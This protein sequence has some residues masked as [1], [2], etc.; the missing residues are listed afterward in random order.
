MKSHKRFAIF[1]LI[2]ILSLISSI[3]TPPAS[4]AQIKRVQ[5]GDVYFD[6]DD[7]S[8]IVSFDA[9][10]QTKTLVF[11]YPDADYTTVHL[12][13]NTLFT[14]QFESDSSLV[15][16]RAAGS[17]GATVRYYLIEFSEG[18]TVQRG[19]SSFL[20]GVITN[21]KYRIK[22]IAL[23]ES[24][25]LDKSISF[26][27]ASMTQSYAYTDELALI[28]S[29]IIN[30]G[31]TLRLE[32]CATN[33]ETRVITMIWQVIEFDTDTLV[34]Q[35]ETFIG[36]S[37]TYNTSAISPVIPAGKLDKCALFYSYRAN[38]TVNGN[39]SL[40]RI[41]GSIQNA[42]L[43]N[44]TRGNQTGA[45][46]TSVWVDWYVAEFQDESTFVQ[47]NVTTLA[48]GET[49]GAV[50]LTN[51][52][53]PARTFVRV[54]VA[55]PNTQTNTY[56]DDTELCP[57]TEKLQ[58]LAF[59][60]STNSIWVT[61]YLTDS[62]YK[63]NA[64]TGNLTGTYPVGVN[65]IAVVY[66]PSNLAV[67]VANYGSNNVTKLYASNGTE[68]GNYS[69][70]T[71][72]MDI[73]YDYSNATTQYI[74]TANYGSQNVTKLYANNGTLRCT[75]AT[76]QVNPTSICYDP[77]G[78]QIY[79]TFW[80]GSTGEQASRAPCYN[81]NVT[82]AWNAIDTGTT[83]QGQIRV[84]W[85][86][87]KGYTGMN[88][89]SGSMWITQQRLHQC[90]RIYV[91][92]SGANYYPELSPIGVAWDNNTKT[93]WITNYASNTLSKMYPNNG[94]DTGPFTTI[95]N[96]YDVVYAPND[97]SMWVSC[98][99]PASLQ[100]FD[101][102]GTLLGTYRLV[103]ISDTIY[104]A[105]QNTGCNL[106][107]HWYVGEFSPVNIK[108]PNGV[109]EV[110]RV[111]QVK[112]IN[113]T[114]SSDVI[115]H[116]LAISA[117]LANS[118][119]ISNYTVINGSVP[120]SSNN[121]GTFNWNVTS[122]IGGANS[123][124]KLVRIGIKDTNLTA[125]NY[126][127]SNAPFEIK[128]DI[129]AVTAPVGGEDWRV[130]ESHDI[131]WTKAGDLSAN[132][133]SISLSSDGGG[134]WTVINNTTSGSATTYNWTIPD[135]AET[136]GSMRIN[137]SWEGDPLN[138]TAMSPAN[139]TVRAK[140]NVT[141]PTT[142]V[143]WLAQS[144]GT[145]T[146]TRNGSW[147]PNTVSIYY[148]NATGTNQLINGSVPANNSTGPNVGSYF[149][150]NITVNASSAA[151]RIYI[152]SNVDSA[153]NSTSEA[154][155]IFPYIEVTYPNTDDVVWNVTDSVP[156]NWTLYGSMDTVDIW[157]NNSSGWSKLGDSVNASG[158][159]WMWYN[160]PVSYASET[161]YIWVAK[162]T[163]AGAPVIP[164]DASNYPA[165]IRGKISVG[166]PALN[167]IYTIN[168]SQYINW[169][170]SGF[171]A[172]EKVRIKFSPS[173]AMDPG[174]LTNLTNATT[175]P[176]ANNQTWTW[177]AVP[178]NVTNVGKIR[179][180]WT[181]NNS[182][183]GDSANFSIK[184]SIDVNLPNTTTT[185]YIGSAMPINWSVPAASNGCIGAVELRYVLENG[186]G[187]S[188]NIS[189]GT[190]WWFDESGQYSWPIPESASISDAV[191]IKAVMANDSSNVSNLSS[192]PCRIMGV[193]NVTSPDNGTQAWKIGSTYPITWNRNGTNLGNINITFFNGSSNITI[194]S[195]YD[196]AVG[197][198]DWTVNNTT[199][200]SGQRMDNVTV[201][202]ASIT[203]PSYTY[204]ISSAPFSIV[205]NI[206][207]TWPDILN[208]TLYVDTNVTI[209][210]TVL[211]D[212]DK[213]NVYYSQDGGST[214]GSPI[215][216]GE[217]NDGNFTWQVPNQNIQEADSKLKICNYYYNLTPSA[218][219]GESRSFT[220]KQNIEILHPNATD[221]PQVGQAFAIQFMPHGTVG[222]VNISWY[223]GS[224]WTELVNNTS[225]TPGIVNT[226]NWPEVPDEMSTAVNRI[227]IESET[228]G[229]VNNTS[230]LFPIVGYINVTEPNASYYAKA[231]S[232]ASAPLRWSYS[233]TKVGDVY[234]KYSTNDGQNWTNISTVPATYGGNYTW[235]LVP[236]LKNNLTR[237]SVT[238]VND[239]NTT[240]MSER[241]EIIGAVTMGLPNGGETWKADSTRE[242]TW[243]AE[244]VSTVSLYYSVNNGTGWTP[245]PDAEGLNA[246]DE[247]FNW[248]ISN[249]M[250]ITAN[251][252]IRIDDSTNSTINDTSD[253]VFNIAPDIN[254]LHPETQADVLIAEESGNITWTW[255]GDFDNITLQYSTDN[256]GNWSYV[257]PATPQ[258]PNTGTYEWT[259][260]NGTVI[261]KNCLVRISHPDNVTYNSTS[262]ATFPIRGKITLDRP[263]DPNEAWRMGNTYP[264]NWTKQGNMSTVNI[265]YSTN[266]GASWARINPDAE[267]ASNGTY[268]WAI[269]ATTTPSSRARISVNYTADEANVSAMSAQYFRVTKLAVTAP[270]GGQ[271]WRSGSTYEITWQ[272]GNISKV[273]VT[274]SLTNG[275]SWFAV[276]NGTDINASDNSLNW[277]VGNTTNC[278]NIALIRVEDTSNATLN[279]TSDA[280]FAV[281]PNFTI[282]HPRNGDPVLAGDPYN[283]T[284][285][286]TGS[287]IGN[288][289]IEY[290]TGGNSSWISI[291][292]SASSTSPYYW[293]SVSGENLSNDCYVRLT[294][295]NNA[296]G[297]NENDLAF[298]IRGNITL[299]APIGG[300]DFQVGNPTNVTWTKSGNFSSVDIYYSP[301]N[302]SN[303]SNWT[304]I[305][306]SP[307]NAS[308][309]TYQ[310]N[311]TYSET[312]TTQGLIR[313]L[314]PDDGLNATYDT[315]SDT[316]NIIG[317]LVLNYPND[318][319]VVLTYDG[320]G[321][322][323]Q[324]NWTRYGGIATVNLTYK[325]YDT[326]NT[327]VI[328]SSVDASLQKYNWTIPDEVGTNMKVRIRDNDNDNVT[329]ESNYSFAIKGTIQLIQ[330]NGNENWTVNSVP[331]PQIQW[332][333]R[334]AYPGMILI[335]YATDN[336]TWK[337][338][339]TMAA[340]AD[341]ATVSYNW[342]VPDDIANTV[343]ARV[344]TQ[345]SD[346]KVDVNDTSDANFS[347]IGNI[348][349]N[350]PTGGQTFL[351]PDS[352]TIDINWTAKGT[353][354]P[355]RIEY[356]LDNGS[357]WD[358]ITNN[359]TG[360]EGYNN[361]SWPTPD[362][363]SARCLIKVSDN[364]TAF[365]DH[366]TN[367]SS[368]V[369][370]IW[371]KL[372]LTEPVSGQNVVAHS[373]DTPIRWTYTGTK[374][375]NVTI[376][377]STNGGTNYSAIETVAV[378]QNGTYVWPLVPTT[379]CDDNARVSITD[380]DDANIS[381]ATPLFNIVGS[382]LL[383][384]PNGGENWTAGSSRQI[385]W[386]RFAVSTLN[387]S[388]STNNGGIWNDINSSY[389]TTTNTSI[390]WDIP[391]D[392]AI[393][394]QA[395]IRIQDTANPDNVSDI[396]DNTFN[397]TASLNILHP[398]T[399]SDV[400][401][402]EDTH[403][404]TWSKT[405]TGLS[406]VKLEYSTD[407][408]GNWSNVNATANVDNNGNYTWVSVNG[409]ALSDNCLVRISDPD[410][411]EVN[412][413]SNATFAIKGKIT[414]TRPNDADENWRVGTAQNITWTKQGN[415]SSVNIYY[416]NNSG[417]SWTKVNAAPVDCAG[418]NYSWTI[419]ASTVPSTQAKISVN[420]TL[421]ESNVSDSSTNSFNV[422][423]L[424]VTSPNAGTENW[425]AGS[426]YE[427]TWSSLAISKVNIRYSTNG[428]SSYTLV[429]G[430]DNVTASDQSFNWTVNNTTA[431]S[432]QALIL[433]EDSSN[434]TVN[435]TSNSTFNFT[436]DL[437]I[438]HPETSGD[439][440]IA[441]DPYY[442]TWSKT[443][444]G[445]SEVKLEYSTDGGGNW[446]NV[447]GT[448]N[449]D[450]N[451]NYT[452]TSVN[453][454]KL[455]DNCLVRVSDP[456]KADSNS[457]SSSAFPI[458]GKITLT[459]PV[460]ADENWRIGTIHNIT[461]TKQ[462]NMSSVNIY[463]SN[464]SGTSWTKVN[465]APVDCAGGNYSWTINASTVPSTQAKI[466]VNYTGDEL[467]VSS[468]ST[469][470][471]NVTKLM[472]TSPN[473][474]TES[475]KSGA[476]YEITWSSLAISKVNLYYSLNN[477]SS[478]TAIPDA[479][480][481]TASNQS[482]NWTIN[483]SIQLSNQTLVLVGDSSNATV[484]DTSN[485][486]FSIIPDL[487]ILHPETQSDVFIAEDTHYITWSKTGTGLSEVKLE[488]S[489]DNGGNW[490]NVNATANVDNN[491]NYTWVSV[492][493]TALSDNC[494]VRVSDPSRA[495]VNSTSN[496][497]FAIKGKVTLTR[498]NDADENW[499][500]GTT[501]NITWTTQGNMSTVNVYYSTNGGTSWSK[502]NPSP[503]NASGGNYSWAIN[504]TTTPTTNAKISVNYTL[505]EGNVSDSS[506]D[507]FK[508]TKLMVTYP[509]NGT[510]FWKA[511]DTYEITWSSLAISKVN[512][513]YSLN[514]GS[515]WSLLPNGDNVTATDQSFNWTIANAT[516]VSN[517]A[518]ILIE[519]ISNATVNDTSNATFAI[520]PNLTITHPQSGDPVRAEDPYNINWTKTGT[521]IG[522]VKL[523]YS[524]N[525]N[526]SWVSINDS[527]SSNPPYNWDPVPADALSEDCY[528]RITSLGNANATDESNTAFYIRGNITVN[529]P[530]GDENIPVGNKTNVTW[531]RKG[532]ITSVN[533]YYSS[534]N[535][536]NWTQ[537]KS[538]APS[539]ATGS[540]E[541]NIDN[542]TTTSTQCLIN[543]T[544]PNNEANV[545][546]SSNNTFN[547]IGRLE[548]TYPANNTTVIT[549]PG[550]ANLTWNKYGGIQYL[551]VRYSNDGGETWP[552][553]KIITNNTS[554]SGSPL[555]WTIVNDMSAEVKIK[556]TDK[557]NANVTAES[558]DTFSIKGSILV[559]SPNGN[560]NITVNTTH[561]I[562]WKTRGTYIQPILLQYS[563]DN[564]SNWTDID[565]A[566]AGGDDEVKNYSWSVP[567]NITD[568]AKVRVLTQENVSTI[569]VTDI[570]NATLKIIGNV[571]IVQPNGG[572]IWYYNDSQ[573]ITWNSKG[574]FPVRIE[575]SND[576][577]VSNWT[578]VNNTFTS[579]PGF[580]AYNWTIPDDNSESCL[581]K[582]SDNRTV[583]QALA[584]DTSNATFSIRPVIDV[585][586]PVSSQNVVA[587]SNDTAIRWTHTGSTIGNVKV[588]YSL[589]GTAPWT[590][591]ATVDV[592]NGSNYVWPL[593]PSSTASGAKIQV[594]DVN[595]A[596]VTNTSEAFNIIGSL[597][598]TQPNGGENW[599]AGSSRQVQWTR[600]AVD[601]LNI[602]YSTNNGSTWNDINSSYDTTTNTSIS[603]DIPAD[604]AINSQ[605]KVRIQDT[606]DPTNVSDISND[607]FNITADFNILHPET[608]SDIFIAEETHYITW[609]KT[610]SGLS[611][612][613][614]E[615]STDGGAVW[616]DVDENSSTVD[617]NGNYTW[618]SVN[619]TILSNDC[620]IRVTDPNKP[621]I[622]STSNTSFIIRGKV[623]LTRPDD[624]NENWRVGGTYP[625]TWTKKGNVTNLNI[626][627][628]S[629]GGTSWSKI[630]PNPIDASLGIYNWTINA[631]T[632]PTTSAKISVNYT[633]DE[634]NVSDSSFD[635]FKV[636]KLLVTYPNNGTE[637]WKAGDTYEITW[638]SASI[639][640]VNVKYSL[641]NG[642][643]WSL[644]PNGDNVT[645]T[646][647]SFNW[648]IGNNTVVSNNA[649][650]F[651]EDTTNSSVND[652]SNATFAIIPNLTITH[653]Q[654]GDPV[655]GEDPYNITWTKSGN[656]TGNVKLEYSTGGNTSWTS[657]NNSTSSTSPYTWNPVPG[658]V[659]SEDCY[660]RITGLDN[661]NATDESNAAFYIRGNIT[662]T[663]PNGADNLQVMTPF[664]IT[665]SRKGNITSV[666]IY[667]SSDNGANWTQIKSNAP[668]GA[669]GSW[670]WNVSVNTTT[671]TQAL[672]N[673]TDSNNEANT[674][675]VSNQTFSVMGKLDI[676]YPNNA[677]DVLNYPAYANITWS[678]YGG[679]SYV[680][681]RYSNDSGETWPDGKIIAAN[682]SA[683]ASPLNWTVPNDI[684]A[685][686]KMKILDTGNI[687]VT[688]ESNST[689]SVKG[690]IMIVAPNGNENWTVNSTQ[691]IQWKTTGT[692]IQP[693]LLQYSDNN[694]TNWTDIDTALPGGDAEVKNLSW[695]IPNNISSEVK[696]RAVTQEN[697]STIDVN[698]TSNA[699]FKIIGNVTITQPN[700]G[701]FWYVNE[702]K[703]I[704]WNSNGTFPVRI[705]Y[706]N[707]SGVSNWTLINNTVTSVPGVNTYNWTVP[708]DNSE[709]C[710]VR[711]SDNRTI[712]Q[713]LARDISDAVFSIRPIITVTQPVAGQNV[714][715][716]STDTAI[717][718]NYT[719]TAFGDVKVQYSTTGVA[720]WTDIATVN[721]SNGSNYIWPEVP[722]VTS[723]T[724]KIRVYDTGNENVT[725]TSGTFN[726][727]GSLMLTSPNGGE[728]WTAGS[729]RQVQWTRYAVSTLNISYSTNN[730]STWNNIN[731]SFDTTTNT[732]CS[733][734]IS[735]DATLSNLTIVRIQ[736]ADNPDNVS[737]I[738][739]NTFNLTPDFNILHPETQSD[740]VTAE[741]TYYISWS[742]TGTG[743]SQ[744]KLE[745][746]TDTG[747]TWNNVDAN[748][749]VSNNGNYTWVSVNGT[750]LADTCL[751]RVSDPNKPTV[752]STSNATFPIKGKVTL[753]RP[754]DASEIW[755]INTN[756]SITW[757][758]QGNMSGVN[759]YYS[760]NNGTN[761]TKINPSPVDAAGGN[762]TW[763]LNS[764]TNASTQAKISVNY[765]AD[766]ANVSDSSENPFK[767][768][769]LTV[770]S[771]NNGTENW[772]ANSTYKITWTSANIDQLNLKYSLNN[773]SSYTLIPGADNLTASDGEFNWSIANTIVTSNNVLVLAEDTGNTS[774]NDTSNATFAIIPNFTITNPQNGIPLI[775][776][777][778]YNITWTKTG[779]YT[780]SVKLEYSLE[781]NTS[782]VSIND[783]ASSNSP[784]TWTAVP[785]DLLSEDCYVRITSLANANATDE[786]N[787][788]FY[789]RGNITVTSPNGD[790]NLQVG[791]STNITWT[792]KGNITAVHIYYSSNDGANWTQIKA[793]APSPSGSGSWEWDVDLNTTT[794]TQC[795][796]NITDPNNEANTWD[797]SNQTFSVMGKLE[798]TQPT[799][800][801]VVLNYPGYTNITWNKYGG[802]SYV[803][804][805]YSNDSGETWPDAKIIANNTSATASPLN[806]T[807]P[808]DISAQ[809][810]IRVID[811]GN[812]NVTDDSNNTFSIK[813]G[814]LLLAPNG[815]ENWTVNST[816]TIQW[817]TTG[818][819][820]Q[821]ILLQYSD[822]NGTNWTDIDTALP[823]G[824][825]EVKNYT[826]T[827]P[828]NISSEAKVRVV[829]QENASTIDVNDTS[830]ATFK[831]I[832]NVTLTQP[833]GGQLWYVNESKE[834]KWNSNGTFPVRI[835][836]SNDSGS[837]NWT[838]INNTVTSVPGVN[839]YNWTVPNDNSE[840]CI[841]KVSDNR[842]VFQSLVKGQSAAVF[843]IRPIITVTQ[844][845]AGQ[846]VIAH[847]I[848]TAIR[849]NYTGT[850]FGDVK[851][852][853][854]T[855]GVAPW[856][857]IATVNVSNGSNYLWPEVPV[858]TSSTTKIRVYD[859]GNENV[860]NTSGTFNIVGSLMV[861]SPNGGENWTAGSS[862]Q[863]GWTRYAVSTLNISYSTNNGS[864]WNNIN[865]SFDTTTNTTCSWDI[866]T[867]A[868]LSNL[869]IVRIQDTSNPDNV[870]DISNNTFNLTP[871]FNILHP[872][873]QSD[874]VTAEETYYISWSKTGIG[875]D[876][877]KL[878][879]STDTGGTW[880]NVDANATVSNNGN[881]TWVSVNGTVLA[882]TCLVR[883]SDPNKPTVNST[884]NATFPIKGKVTLTRPND[885]S[886]IWR[887]NT[888]QSITW[889]KQGNMSGVNIYYSINNG[890][891][892]T[893][894]NP[895]PVDAAGGN[896]TWDLNSS[897]NAST[898][899]K[900]S[901]NYTADEANVSDSSENP[902]KV[903]RL[904]VTS[905][906]NGTENWKANST[907]K[908]TWTSANIDQLNLKYSL[909][910]GSS[911]TLIPGADNLTAS[912]GE[913]NWSIANTIV[914]SNNVLVLAED[915]GNTSVND[916]SNATFAI[917]PNFT[918]TNPQNGIPLIAEDPY[919]ITWT[920]TGNY[921][922][923]VKLEYS[924]EGNTSWVA[925]N[926]ST[927]SNSP[928]TWTAVPGDLLSEDCYVRIT[929]LA[930]ANATDES[931]A[932]FYIRGNI[933]VTSPNGNE[934]MQV[935]NKTNIT[936]TRKGNITAVHIYYSSNDGANWTQ[937]KA[938]APSP[939]G[940]GSWEWDVDLNTTTS[941]QCRINITDPNNEANTWD[942]SNTTFS[943]IG[944]LEVTQPTNGT[945]VLNYPGY[946][947]ISW[948]KY[949]GISYVQVRYS[950]DSGE[951][952][953]D[954]KIIAPNIS[955]TASP[956]NWT[957][958]NDISAQ[959][960]VKVIDTGNANVTDD[961]NNT[962]S[963]KGGILLLAPNGNENWTVNSTQTI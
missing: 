757:T 339:Y 933:T 50:T 604:T 838:L 436:P 399:Q 345:V 753:T 416:S 211:G 79:V 459:A 585:T 876:Q 169:T 196:S 735:T 555:N 85:A 823:G 553:S 758:K 594:Y 595:N 149:W 206:D 515:S 677:T 752:N 27:D 899:A 813:G 751:V 821:P 713:T 417:T 437:N 790:E 500:V 93:V 175:D 920:K 247:S 557:D 894:I 377:Y 489:T 848:D 404:I 718:W 546:D 786:S 438:L 467:N 729:S 290:S 430:A 86:D 201:R 360:V 938:N 71:K 454:T 824:D 366:A 531:S 375:K 26:V 232:I 248:S 610:G 550:Y 682:I 157:Y 826:W 332:K 337:G 170:A 35:G 836:Y 650:I 140:I 275:S 584:T 117:N 110:W 736:D 558:N 484:N 271:N 771:P 913:F 223:N 574:T 885:A 725:N 132:N 830:N 738:S 61:G 2:A 715:A 833:N 277:T 721:V 951:T 617:N 324:V 814:I 9:V 888:N 192:V 12:L 851:V 172:S 380:A 320:T 727:V 329:D 512:V 70:G 426:T 560:E 551:Q 591:I 719:G 626:Y 398:E 819:Y 645:A 934:N 344:L 632:T 104:L 8:A 693:I 671:S 939:S 115:G 577:G 351:Y 69:V 190:G 379:T 189:N 267:N 463:Y 382:I 572:Q 234:I 847:S 528:V 263:N 905:P 74:W 947:N 446:S 253:A 139:F 566:F 496:A 734:D 338:N 593:V 652:T 106:T 691:T 873:T 893:K 219:G 571:S 261:S 268:N 801:S 747:G 47:T 311:I 421:D 199:M 529:A 493:G 852:Q 209:Q 481:I 176:V 400:F 805:R 898:Q 612:V 419:N 837:S 466:S 280:F 65:P 576:S 197:T 504:A 98:S 455:S 112:Q 802:I 427:I 858:T 845:A 798:V 659:L 217:A 926:N 265:Y 301:D 486:T 881:Y 203:Y 800:A 861:T 575:Y 286:K 471:F 431:I 592:A 872:E 717:R 108:D 334:G 653:P 168:S 627:Y 92:E 245:I 670:E 289:K 288:V 639:S 188:T 662:V 552:D 902:F 569:D 683:T 770:T 518:S 784:Y 410:K 3:L 51:A 121:T 760:I 137:V 918:I 218:A 793:N 420:Y 396:C 919:N 679:I 300:E 38:N 958:P 225:T 501:Q 654:N 204:D 714:I 64:T 629:N 642:S 439:I 434:A 40:Y 433:V 556:V 138:V 640:K 326:N 317:T 480:N 692:Y 242:I 145:I 495:D 492:N 580:N 100:H 526:T 705:E 191:R 476:T 387:I 867:D 517:N 141:Y 284:W 252:S 680:Q 385:Q 607:T 903:I 688:D 59:D 238:D 647:Q 336:A 56:E 616:H 630:N 955:A 46:N 910:N 359:F 762:Y 839:T 686:L 928:Y 931:N 880:N 960:K 936:W 254:V 94:T 605:A 722:I 887:I 233:G 756:Q 615:Y 407:S 491:G 405:G 797:I 224:S 402:A 792:R 720:P 488:Y 258:V 32:R 120:A 865:S 633:L 193:L 541:W 309:G 940:S 371:P 890:T 681:V 364:R 871:D 228:Y 30:D 319:G 20:A 588:Q 864:T 737:D 411:A 906:N 462:G 856:T 394:N 535:G 711:V 315:S 522:N 325:N 213:V 537:I 668:S 937:I 769:R 342:T 415:M 870:S 16:S 212:L 689:F 222:K 39:E 700:G 7:T 391:S 726:I 953:P 97:T 435:D 390:S 57:E 685:N 205:P 441:E 787:A 959:L 447:N 875:L 820:I 857:D 554:A 631:T 73:A 53:N 425:K 312:T 153:V 36:N 765:T 773:G 363:R 622:N 41:D 358:D 477:G 178:K 257:N 68:I 731:D 215:A 362:E 779:N 294:S 658:E 335:Q 113:W 109:G 825:T 119:N 11:L 200:G 177:A 124:G 409:T 900:I 123:I 635:S 625:I 637:F 543:I 818:T 582:V 547:I 478:Y 48:A 389:D 264:I 343:K 696:V 702:S 901:V 15:I 163:T 863:V 785:G 349:L 361:Y 60:P 704:K 297:S 804:V 150:D 89:S 274:Y 533:I 545:W 896:Y 601:T 723:S 573:Q 508:V 314:N 673:I 513:K 412:S 618:E 307:I 579:N 322:K 155:T 453:G 348:S 563:I 341:N 42:T 270:N 519:D 698:D 761:W 103:N 842:S 675:D 393:T 524:I 43:V 666:N 930:N 674:W 195:S 503:V 874:L 383:T 490:S 643:S 310:W 542:N 226:F 525:G 853:Y 523:E 221:R 651:I 408:G 521:V 220:I 298:Y 846:N 611:N 602:S 184:G 474:G 549:Y 285:N 581:V 694:G 712:F 891:N 118:T 148:R 432:N 935:G 278:S 154:F 877:V 754:N 372:N 749:T 619:G 811:K 24:V 127:V 296:N 942:I 807:I 321:S 151:T 815:N 187:A 273:N 772:K 664:N 806:W 917:I 763:D 283:I 424:M 182:T 932:G 952:W 862:R 672:I 448:G 822:N 198:A 357:N 783:S 510:E 527:T 536:A 262:N 440:V 449:V 530:N 239:S 354:T 949:G 831:I 744:V 101:T 147:S 202:I 562:Q 368:S 313:V 657:I 908:I 210:W 91:N 1:F 180:E 855:T 107:A 759:I 505:D 502:I 509:N 470:V 843:S 174:N 164:S 621:E 570:S 33:D 281:I 944:R 29:R 499:R 22:D 347:I 962:F 276:P 796:I 954:G 142:G 817:R 299:T 111:G 589:A 331:K 745:Y 450:N 699:T 479:D 834:I 539:G 620:R 249:S 583:F 829:T 561:I 52:T 90:R 703:E 133:F 244:A 690:G 707:D 445:L 403:Y 468:A 340:G 567:N 181:S 860:T 963:I 812:A 656:Y 912:D 17:A 706:S 370:K 55:G 216:E 485:A 318:D 23:P 795:R 279:D 600:Y 767:V 578:V 866:S 669:T 520:I 961:S 99:G 789:I 924:L 914:T 144:N 376:A 587:H 742:K 165:R 304:K 487:N 381:N 227:R 255:T 18:V 606:D 185:Y 461:W 457:T 750:V 598:L 386:T 791:N 897:T 728:N 511:G 134:N 328:N 306:P 655:I 646:D 534:D 628:S 236:S 5:T 125:R 240:N 246:G 469:N 251:A 365:Y 803:Q 116:T 186:S 859:T 516:Q 623:D 782:W 414:L 956:I 687:N 429:P 614:L 663:S 95:A 911:Y 732:T 945:T 229:G 764:S 701:Q 886:E 350:A 599:T 323:C 308:L 809:L 235:P 214:W 740:L 472:V 6:I 346:A 733:W 266:D 129:P 778:P 882:D 442:I 369:F 746:S 678:K 333:T 739:N 10:D 62:I 102:D 406:E 613:T 835:E 131:T 709:G 72:P 179:V 868:V 854:S 28:S 775:A 590:D 395:K 925:I 548:M 603:W 564:G 473:A 568:V 710:I 316:F 413:T 730:G 827:I 841:V 609:S 915:T 895:S 929:S 208:T 780:G 452:W 946:V 259:S 849:W 256:G 167:N 173:G 483:S 624:A 183:Y 816:Q 538:N 282:T 665:W 31:A 943:V 464:N 423:K 498:P 128:G 586:Q 80:S 122:T 392:T 105:R 507:S 648:S 384:Q 451:G 755:R 34:R 927:T 291:N 293:S 87:T 532:S 166:K 941:T 644:L 494:L 81:N 422:T 305:N 428:G 808:N 540:W 788:G 19:L 397:I 88:A 302:G 418:G 799:N 695:T 287:N 78:K 565:T 126:D 667:Y 444:T 878:E 482:F 828:N 892:W 114:Q 794:S 152:E 869:T 136:G 143:E 716:Y 636:T 884:S 76:S 776:E 243:N 777:D 904:T 66:D 82:V 353:V 661:A 135:T 21:D 14:S 295:V 13:R 292:D 889:T 25:E 708:N 130:G 465:A 355:V 676:S 638:Q 63:V 367:Q 146:W 774:V 781:G 77:D 269:N 83:N 641:N 909:N 460:D 158:G 907:Y 67:W 207:V 743:L 879:Y 4:A 161:A 156:I 159:T 401:I 162:H 378:T 514:N 49:G 352:A 327:T 844:P 559:I 497:T 194:Y 506:F 916:T 58:G 832:G 957:I 724:T 544:D 84:R 921:T 260:V 443:G 45:T 356:S 388:Y 684:S 840:G 850:A 883:V 697:A 748:A 950:N 649:L 54:G 634:A 660:V 373:S 948:S 458:K 96:P 160:I 303:I 475:W 37:A 922:G 272:S 608:Q 231:G 768:I 250:P 330:P 741:E 597:L 923:N 596:N 766:E 237:I 374:I 810:F 75:N 456:A 230:G 171:G 44:F 241:F